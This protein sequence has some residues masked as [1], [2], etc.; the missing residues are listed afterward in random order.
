MCLSFEEVRRLHAASIHRLCVVA[1][2]HPL[3][4]EATA[5][6]VLSVGSAAFPVDRPTPESALTWLLRIACE[7]IVDGGPPRRRRRRPAPAPPSG[8]GEEVDAAIAGVAGLSLRQRLATGL[9]CAGGLEYAE[10][11]AILGIRAEAA[12]SACLRGLRRVRRRGAR[13]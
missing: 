6:H 7:V 4:A 9:R 8:W 2:A 13:R 5:G 12:R 10:I 1:L 3:A 11:G